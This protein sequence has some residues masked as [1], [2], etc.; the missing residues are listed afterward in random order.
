MAISAQPPLENSPNL[1]QEPKAELGS[2]LGGGKKVYDQPAVIKSRPVPTRRLIFLFGFGIP[3]VSIMFTLG[4][5]WIFWVYNLGLVLATVLTWFIAPKSNSFKVT[6][7]MDTSLSVRV[8]NKVELIVENTGF[9]SV[10]VRVRDESPAS[11]DSSE[12][13][14]KATIDTG[15][16]ARFHYTVTPPER[17]DESF[18]GTFLRLSC[19]LGLIEKQV[20]L[21]TSQGIEVYPNLLALREFDF[22]NQQGRLRQLG[23]R[24]AKI[25]GL[26]TDFES[27][28]EYAEGDDFRKIDW[29]A[30][31]R[32]NKLIVK[33]FEV[34]RNQSLILCVDCGRHMLA[35]VEGV[36]KL[37]HVLDAILLLANAAAQAGDQVGLLVYAENVR[38]YIPPKKGKGQIGYIIK[39][40]HALIAEPIESD[41]VASFSFLSKRYKRR[42]L[43]VNFT[44]VEDPDRAK[45]LVTS[46]GA[47]SKNHVALLVDVGDPRLKEILDQPM[48]SLEQISAVRAVQWILEDKR[49]AQSLVTGAGIHHLESEPQDLGRALVNYYLHVKAMAIL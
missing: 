40:L 15:R 22:L 38:Q 16:E 42:S 4:Q 18:L 24:K 47:L 12:R 27:L 9:E 5:T 14:W 30:S 41:P 6:R 26:G 36:R 8:K 35:E 19:P 7:K 33:Q 32:R 43:L 13:D 31:A 2:L 45:D 23:I 11:F 1:P 46:F 34:E 39:A 10:L 25:R 21:D 29:K 49:A 48:D 37:D 17:G 44:A 28:R 3:L 20:L